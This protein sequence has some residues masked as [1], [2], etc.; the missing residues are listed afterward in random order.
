MSFKPLTRFRSFEESRLFPPLL[1][2]E[3][4]KEANTDTHQCKMDYSYSPHCFDYHSWSNTSLMCSSLLFRYFFLQDQ[5]QAVSCP[6]KLWGM[7]SSVQ[8][9]QI[10]SPWEWARPDKVLMIQTW[11]SFFCRGY[12]YLVPL[13][14]FLSGPSES[15]YFTL[16]NG[17]FHKHFQDKDKVQSMKTW[18]MVLNSVLEKLNNSMSKNTGLL[19]WNGFSLSRK[20]LDLFRILSYISIL[21]A[22]GILC[23][24][25]RLICSAP[26]S[27]LIS[28][29]FVGPAAAIILI[30]SCIS[31]AVSY[32]QRPKFYWEEIML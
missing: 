32:L 25:V 7:L 19:W 22:P 13:R 4:D 14:D 11:T 29:A 30:W 9:A 3:D 8:K 21:F 18:N 2:D 23:S 6:T 31:A 26:P 27:F 16:M 20:I 12:D 17:L 5:L 10:L 24:S 15:L 1:R 28:D